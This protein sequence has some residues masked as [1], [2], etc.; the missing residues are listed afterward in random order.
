[1]TDDD[2]PGDATA[3]GREEREPQA[4]LD[5]VLLALHEVGETLRE[6]ALRVGVVEAR[7]DALPT[8]ADFSLLRGQVRSSIDD[9][10]AA[11]TARA[12]EIADGLED[13]VSRLEQWEESYATVLRS[14]VAA[15]EGRLGAVFAAA[16]ARMRTET[17]ATV[18]AAT[19][20]VREELGAA[21]ESA[22]AESASA[23]E[24]IRRDLATVIAGVREEIRG[25]AGRLDDVSARVPRADRLAAAMGERI[26]L[27]VREIAD[28]LARIEERAQPAI[29]IPVAAVAPAPD[30]PAAP[31]SMPVPPLAAVE[32][33]SRSAPRARGILRRWRAARGQRTV[34]EDVACAPDSPKGEEESHGGFAV[35]DAIAMPLP[36]IALERDEIVPVHGVGMASHEDLPEVPPI[37]EPVVEER[38]PEEPIDFESPVATEPI[39]SESFAAA[40]TTEREEPLPRP[41]LAQALELARELQSPPPPKPQ[42]RPARSAPK[43]PV[44]ARPRS[45]A[46]KP[47]PTRARRSPRKP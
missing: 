16:V 14:E 13:V 38:S 30:E 6:A 12:R 27:A 22:R 32:A 43:Q 3:D 5:D 25:V 42:A 46:K 11:A 2:L 19:A 21:L 37:P 9:G 39:D 44:S 4:G 8:V 18:A 20:M 34:R 7:I 47:S 29:E 35:A 15:A 1:M 33:E 28:G 45:P 23:H 40:D 41:E 10:E 26:D 24:L 36:M 17:A 31:V